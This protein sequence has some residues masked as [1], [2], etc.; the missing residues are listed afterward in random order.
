MTIRRAATASPPLD[1]RRIALLQHVEREGTISAAALALNFSCSGLSQQLRQLEV[2]VGTPLVQRSPKLATLTPA[3]HALLEHGVYVL[4]RLEQAEREAR[5]VAHLRGG[6]LRMATFRSA[7]ETIVAEAVAYFGGHWPEVELRLLEGEPEDYLPRLRTGELDLALAFEYDGL[8]VTPDERLAAT[9]LCEEDMVV[10]MR[11]D[12]PLAA[13]RQHQLADLADASWVASSRSVTVDF[14]DRACEAAGFTPRIALRTD[15]YHVA[16]ALVAHIGGVAF[17]PLLSARALH[18][19]LVARRLSDV[20]LR[21][22][23]FAAHRAG[24]ERAP[25]VAAMLRVLEQLGEDLDQAGVDEYAR[26]RA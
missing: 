26:T 12:D 16:Q 3:G 23:T 10:V 15:D 24:G 1:P 2:Q 6:R 7:G 18:P 5:A 4:E 9:L 13:S 22:R 25:A 19:D 14:T 11:A 17:L 8:P 20:R 21:R